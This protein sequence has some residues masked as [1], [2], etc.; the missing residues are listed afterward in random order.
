MAEI[1]E[2]RVTGTFTDS[3]LKLIFFSPMA[4]GSR[5]LRS[6]FA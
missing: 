3:G 4:H 1:C 2:S 6:R 5:I